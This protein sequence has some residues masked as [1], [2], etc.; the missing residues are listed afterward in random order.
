MS[1]SQQSGKVSVMFTYL[2][3]LKKRN[4]SLKTNLI[5][6]KSL[7][8][9]IPFNDCSMIVVETDVKFVLTSPKQWNDLLIPNSIPYRTF[10][11]QRPNFFHKVF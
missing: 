10:L 11:H 8:Q 1:L 6:L 7:I 9:F 4:Q 2:L 3:K 5:T